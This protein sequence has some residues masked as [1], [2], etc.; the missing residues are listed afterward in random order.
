MH[1]QDSYPSFLLQLAGLTG[2]FKALAVFM[3]PGGDNGLY[4]R[5]LLEAPE[6]LALLTVMAVVY[7]AVRCT[8]LVDAHLSFAVSDADTSR[9]VHIYECTCM[10][11]CL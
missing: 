10:S 5:L 8:L 6:F 4:M 9:L 1:V 3:E 2:V 7:P 11:P